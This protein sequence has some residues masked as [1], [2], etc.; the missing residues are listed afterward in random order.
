[1]MKRTIN[2]SVLLFVLLMLPLKL[3]AYDFKVDGLFY[4]ING[5]GKTVTLTDE[6]GLYPKYPNLTGSLTI[7]SS[8]TYNGTTYS[9]TCIDGYAFRGCI[10]L[11]SVTIPN[12]VTSIGD[13]AF[14]GCDG[15]TSITSF[16]TTPPVVGRYTFRFVNTNCDLLVPERSLSVYAGAAFW[17]EF[18][19]IIGI[20]NENTVNGLFFDINPDSTSVTVT[21]PN[22][23]LPRYDSLA[24][25]LVIPDVIE[26]KGKTYSVTAIGSSA[27]EGCVSLSSVTIPNSVT[28]IGGSAFNGCTGL[29]SVSIGNSVTSI[30]ERAFSGCT[31]LS[32]VTIPNSVTS[33][34][35]YAFYGCTGLT[36]VT[37]GNSV[38][39]IGG[40]AFWGCSNLTSVTIPNSVTSIGGA[41]FWG[42]TGL[43]SVTIGN[44]VTSI[45]G[46]AFLGCSGLK[47]VTIPDSVTSIGYWAFYG[48]TGLTS[49]TIGNS[50][51][52]IDDEAF[53][54]CSNL[55][56]ITSFPTSPPTIYSSTFTGF[57]KTNCVLLVPDGSKSQYTVARYWNE[58]HRF[59]K[60][61]SDD[62]VNGLFFDINPDG[63]SVT[64]TYQNYYSP[65]YSS[66][67]TELVIPDVIVINGKT[68]SVSAIGS[69]AFEGCTGLSSVT[70]PNSV[71]SIG[72]NA[73]YNCTGLT[74]LTIPKSVAQ[75]GTN[76]FS[77][78]NAVKTL[79]WNAVNCSSKGNLPSS[80]IETVTIGD[81]V[82]VIPSYFAGRSKITS[83]VIP[84]SVTSIG[85]NAFYNCF[86]LSNVTIGNSVTSIGKSAFSDTGLMNVTIPNSV[87]SIGENAFKGCTALIDLSIGNS[88]TSIGESAFQGC[89]GIT[90]ITSLPMS[91]PMISNNTFS[92]VD[93]TNCALLVPDRSMSQ[94]AGARYWKDFLRLSKISSDNTLDGLYFDINPDGTSVT[95][96]Y[97]NNFSP[98]YS[99]LVSDLVIPDNI[100]IN[101]KTYSVTAIG[102][103]AF[104]GCT[105]ITSLTIPNSVTSIG[106]HAFNGCTG[107]TSITIP[108]SVTS[109]GDETF[110]GCAGLTSLTIPKSVAQIGTD[111]FAG[112]DAVKSFT[113]N[114]VNCSSL[115]SLPTAQIE[116]VTIGDS[117]QV[118]PDDFVKNSKILSVNIPTSVTS[119]GSYAFSGCT[120]LTSV[121][122][123][124]AVTSIGQATFEGC[125]GLTSLTIGNS[126]TSIGDNAF[127]GCN[128]VK[129]LT[130]N[131]VN[132]SSK[133]HL[134]SSQIE[135]VTIG[136]SVQ[137]IPENFVRDS[138]ITSLIIPN[139]VKTI[140]NYAFLNCSGLTSL[141]IPRFVTQIGIYAFAG[142]D[143][144]K[145]LT[146]NAVNCSSHGSL[147]TAQIETVSLGESV[148]VIPENFVR[149]SKITSLIIPNSVRII[150]NYAFRDCSGLT[151]VTIPDL[152]TSIGARAFSGCNGVTIITS[153][154][155]S[156]PTISNYTFSDI[157]KT[158][159]VLLVP[160]GS[161]SQYA[162]ARYWNEFLR[163]G[164]IPSDNTV[165]GLFFVINPDST[166]V[167]VT[168]QN[169]YSPRYNSLASEL[170]IPNAIVLNGKTYSVTEISSSAFSDCVGLTSVS[171]P[172]SVT[173]I[174]ESAFSGCT[175]LTS[176]TI[177]NS[178]TSIDAKAFDG[179]NAVKMLTWNAVNC[180]SLGNLPI[181]QLETVTIGDS[182]QFIPNNFVSNSMITSVNIPN[183]VL[184]IGN[185]A[186]SGCTGLT[187]VSIPN[188]VT[189][190]GDNAFSH[191]NAVKSLTWNAVNC[192]S[193]G[194]LPTAQIETFSIGRTVQVLPAGFAA[195]STI[196]AVELPATLRVIGSKAFFNCTN[197]KTINWPSGLTDIGD[198]A[199]RYC[200]GI[201]SVN[202]PGTLT[203]IGTSAFSYCVG[204]STVTITSPAIGNLA[205]DPNAF[206]RCPIRTLNIGGNGSCNWE[207]NLE[208]IRSASRLNIG[209]EVTAL[210]SLQLSP[211]TIYSYAKNP[212]TLSSGT[213]AA[214]N[215]ALHVPLAGAGAYFNAPYW[216]NFNNVAFDANDVISLTPTSATL[217]PNAT[218]ALKV[219]SS[220]DAE[221]EWSSTDD[222]V[223]MVSANGLVVALA[224]GECDIIA[225]QSGSPLISATCH[226]TVR[227]G[228]TK[229]DITGDGTIDIGD[230]NMVIALIVEN[231]DNPAADLNGDSKVDI[232]DLNALINIILGK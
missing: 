188:S 152:V 217:A 13:R 138:K 80:Q 7:P 86:G 204:V 54:G 230:L 140:G 94:Y 66:L 167:T 201:K 112:C 49:V 231:N 146:W 131:A 55:T 215:A 44:S 23:Y 144:V 178:V 59:G 184:N 193:M 170:V 38:T 110:R 133:G 97:Q 150:G 76:A 190:I 52:A 164:K 161:M 68:Y 30:G 168:Y 83:V 85:D 98:R 127:S 115:G 212:P 5:D 160:D 102:A 9:V 6:T 108:N 143:V 41:A 17:K 224:E 149:D 27:F 158:N 219:T 205:I 154:P 56:S 89:T 101:G 137:V 189:T 87:I 166:S 60:I 4:Y 142:C 10:G 148:Q 145:S 15:L 114:A 95:V 187:S 19:Q 116:T 147:P 202:L 39:S 207:A 29:T 71:M 216:K 195:G 221:I 48:C 107:L 159:C 174:G 121:T 194:G 65:R 3:S 183:S 153:L 72:D 210:G 73:F 78:C 62:T 162:G 225:A 109:I 77:G 222:G 46:R 90:I 118:I 203:H 12:S 25:E 211:T 105:G 192:S 120:G 119:I 128:A 61:S 84:N 63:T 229:G 11:T 21:Y 70:I 171:I 182:V 186:F 74:S 34:G 24:S 199:F 33:I 124:N 135:T 209:P 141:T 79:T 32:S 218:L 136:D 173:S 36:S 169:T 1:M 134:P 26:L 8:V 99:S 111:A 104:S 22:S 129:S 28:S 100:V 214:Y 151:S 67:A 226:I 122:I 93:K 125:S 200:V 165:N 47:S 103:S 139:M 126:V 155:M 175:G 37:I 113:W 208:E 2:L 88:V 179:C 64:V 157:D 197:L 106:E 227:N 31:G 117:V 213:F 123:G 82:Q 181:T 53:S 96:T 172:N 163:L 92:G 232:S 177:G 91:P 180:S 223:A 14:D 35:G 176:L 156:P 16:P 50:V 45:G 20:P 40:G 43:T 51:T 228:S 75:I 196:A 185:N 198:E 206:E 57:D 81:S 42:C 132:C 69:S 18:P 130:W 191:C 220:T 58:F